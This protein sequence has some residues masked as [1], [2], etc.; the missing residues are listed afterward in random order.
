M[1][2]TTKRI[3]DFILHVNQ[4]FQEYIVRQAERNNHNS[5]SFETRKNPL[6][7]LQIYPSMYN[8][9]DTFFYN[10]YLDYLNA[11]PTFETRMLSWADH[12]D[13]LKLV[14]VPQITVMD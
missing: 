3:I 10:Y 12:S 11:H 5:S 13:M 6:I 14:V 9:K 2:K 7:L 1:E 8:H 4:L